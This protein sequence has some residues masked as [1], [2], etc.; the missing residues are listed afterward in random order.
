M[1]RACSTHGGDEKWIQNFGRK[2]EGKKQFL[3]SE[4]KWEDNIKMALK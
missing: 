4:R 1:D 2:S 3:R